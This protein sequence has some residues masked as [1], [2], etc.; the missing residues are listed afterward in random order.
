MVKCKICKK[1]C[2]TTSALSSHIKTHG[3][4]KEKYISEFGDYVNT[5]N[6]K[7]CN[8]P[9]SKHR[10][11][12]SNECKFS[13][14]TYNKQ[15]SVRTEKINDSDNKILEC[16][17]CGKETT[18]VNNFSGFAKK[19]LL[20]KHNIDTDNYLEYYNIKDKPKKEKLEC[21]YCD[22]TTND[23]NNSSGW[24]TKHLK[25]QHNISPKEFCKHYP[26]L[27]YLWNFKS[28]KKT[29]IKKI[30]INDKENSGVLCKI[31]NNKYQIT[32]MATHI[33]YNHNI[34]VEEYVGLYGE[35]RPNK[36]ILNKRKHNSNIKCKICNEDMLSER[37]LTYH[38]RLEHSISKENY[39]LKYHFNNN[40]PL[41][42]CGCG[43]S[44]KILNQPPYRRKYNSN[45][46]QPNGMLGK[47]HSNNSKK[48]MAK[49]AIE[50]MGKQNHNGTNIENSFESFL[51][52]NNIKYEKQVPTQYGC[53]DFK[54]IDE[55][56]Y[57]E[58]DGI[59]WHPLKYENL[60]FQQISSAISDKRKSEL[61][62]L[63]RIR[64]N[65]VDHIKKLS[66]LYQYNHTYNFII[67]Y[68]QIIISKDY[69]LQHSN[70]SK[71][72]WL[73]IKFLRTFTPEY[74]YPESRWEFND[75]LKRIKNY[76]YNKVLIGKTF[77]NNT[78]VVGCDYLKGIFKSY[79]KTSF[80]NNYSPYDVYHNDD[81]LRKIIINR[82]GL[83]SNKE[84]YDFSLKN[85]NR[86]MSTLR[87]TASFFKPVLA[88]GIY[89]HFLSDNETPT[90]IDPCSGFGGRLLGFKAMYP[91]GTYIGIEPNV[92]TFQE[93]CK[94]ADNFN[95]VYLYNMTAEEY[96]K[97]NNSIDCDLTFTS[98]PYYNMEIY[99]NHIYYKNIDSWKNQFLEMGI[100]KFKNK[101]I[102]FP[103]KLRKYFP[104]GDE[105]FLESN[106]SHF[107]KSTSK[108]IEYILKF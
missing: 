94:L 46:C 71:Y 7:K 61:D 1:E 84:V 56:I 103:D 74:P 12:C 42:E 9:I 108:K 75:I 50:R 16:K 88:A 58:I 83:G 47:I 40:P 23:L 80:E 11:Y 96:I 60:N 97:R 73:L 10:I 72:I 93:L 45:K 36:I 81:M 5:N 76:D 64:G 43:K 102:N 79:W 62:G 67:P 31:C 32:G 77:N 105:Y 53:I 91:N 41:C 100:F 44:V 34:S 87:F 89:K 24:F 48:T 90:V 55:N 26:E 20:K 2:K 19:H 22:W 99:S 28:K 49:K 18:D 104:N 57:V 3:Y 66:N 35:Y 39:I 27:Q 107:N 37:H 15:R 98:I 70:T 101:V 52:I 51:N 21:P 29:N 17:E 33:I 63:I 65:N 82:L 54:L 59:Y 30:P 86:G 14:N 4:T 95:N 69:I 78:S 106:T 85:I 6:C 38:L 13:D 25:K 68:R 8:K 92:E